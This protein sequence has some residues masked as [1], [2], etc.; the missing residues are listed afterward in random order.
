M[1]KVAR[2][3]GLQLKFLPAMTDNDVK[4]YWQGRFCLT[5]V[6]KTFDFSPQM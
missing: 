4:I 2:T 3:K 6:S 1:L 5:P